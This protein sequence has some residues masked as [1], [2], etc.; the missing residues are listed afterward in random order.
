MRGSTDLKEATEAWRNS[1]P[2]AESIT[3]SLTTAGL[4]SSAEGIVSMNLSGPLV[5]WSRKA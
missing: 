1:V 4:E 3:K 2:N 5:Q